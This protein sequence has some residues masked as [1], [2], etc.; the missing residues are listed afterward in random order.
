MTSEEVRAIVEAAGD[1]RR[2]RITFSDGVMQSVDVAAIDAF[3]WAL[4]AY[5]HVGRTDIRLA[6]SD[7]PARCAA[8]GVREE[9]LKA[10]RNAVRCV[11]T[12]GARKPTADRLRI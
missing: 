3:T 8:L 9:I 10:A 12:S 2:F 5:G 11:I 6:W 4:T 7:R 1:A